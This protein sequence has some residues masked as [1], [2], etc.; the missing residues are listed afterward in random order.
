MKLFAVSL[1]TKDKNKDVFTK[2]KY[3]YSR[4]DIFLH[5]CTMD[6]FQATKLVP[7]ALWDTY[8]TII[9]YKIAFQNCIYDNVLYPSFRVEG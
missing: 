4:K 8:T 7:Y 2:E 6:C 5:F 1:A 3:K 9:L